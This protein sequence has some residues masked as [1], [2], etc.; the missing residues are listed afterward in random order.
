M[1]TKAFRV[2]CILLIA[3]PALADQVIG[4]SDGDT[5]TVLRDRQP[6]KIRLAEID[7]PEKTQPL[8][9]PRQAILE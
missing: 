3:F 1:L 4:I 7:S 6:I 8:W 9:K 2:V 5:L